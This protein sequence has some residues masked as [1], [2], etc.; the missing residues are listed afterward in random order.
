M[1]SFCMFDSIMITTTSLSLYFVEGELSTA[2]VL[3]L[4]LV[5]SVDGADTDSL[6]Q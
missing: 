1:N 4:G 2:A 5:Q 3:H 6:I